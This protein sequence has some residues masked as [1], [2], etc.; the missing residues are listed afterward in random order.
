MRILLVSP[1]QENIYGPGIRPPY[2][3][4]GLLYI[5]AVLLQEG[6]NVELIDFDIDCSNEDDF[7]EKVK[8]NK[9]EIVG[10]TTVTPTF[11]SGLELAQKIKGVYNPF[12]VFG[13][14]H[15]SAIA[16]EIIENKNIDGIIIGEGEET[17]IEFL[18]HK[19][20]DET[21]SVC[22]MIQKQGKKLLKGGVRPFIENLDKLP[23]PA[24][25]LL[26]HKEKYSP[27]DALRLPV[28]TILTSRGCP[29]R[30]TFCQA[31]KLWGRKIRR[32]SVANVME[33]IRYLTGIHNI[34]EIHFADDD[35]SHDKEWTLKILDAMKRENIKVRFSFM[36]G[37][38]ITSVDEELLT[39]M[40]NNG[41]INIGFGIESGSQ[42]ILNIVKKGLNISEVIR[43]MKLTKK[44][45]FKTWA[46]FILGLPGETPI[47]IRQ[48][49]DFSL[50]LDPDFAK[51]FYLVPYPGTQVYD[52]FVKK[53]YIKE[54]DFSL[55]GLYTKPVYEFP[56]LSRNDIQKAL[57]IA[58]LKFY[59]RPRK[60]LSILFK[61]RSITELKLNFR[62]A[63]FL[64]RKVLHP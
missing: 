38:R 64:I 28:A 23:F 36:N 6:Y 39:G 12:V 59:L 45:G 19:S 34:K 33:E 22:G 25:K 5:G 48:T 50:S 53:N 41:F 21:R 42:R 62:A 58:Y 29:Y 3:P 14:P 24:W 49:V 37:L 60:M 52:E 18:K 10:F 9:P 44:M 7:L 27:P 35:F 17:I 63:L 43:K 32:R 8:L 57:I 4:L 55:Y 51:F 15:A 40:K 31:P 1:S 46:F 54:K 56:R 20:K 11:Q 30:C 61:I 47:T 26:K 16:D 13:G 2:P